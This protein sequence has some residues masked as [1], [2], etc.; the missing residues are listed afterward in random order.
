VWDD[1]QMERRGV[2]VGDGMKAGAVI[3]VLLLSVTLP[4]SVLAQEQFICLGNKATGFKWDG[5]NWVVSRFNGDEDKFLVQEITPKELSGETVNFEAKKRGESKRR[6]A[7]SC[8]LRRSARSH[9][10]HN[11]GDGMAVMM[12]T[13]WPCGRSAGP[14]ANFK[15]GRA[16]R[17][18]CSRSTVDEA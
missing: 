8:A 18:T 17:S 16:W 5:K 15:D 4:T 12:G 1:E 6:Q 9:S 10:N 13:G 11:D 7:S 2:K 3:R 14:A